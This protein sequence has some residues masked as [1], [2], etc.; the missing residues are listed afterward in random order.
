MVE[1]FPVEGCCGAHVDSFYRIFGT[2]YCSN[3]QRY[4]DSWRQD[5][6]KQTAK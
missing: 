2:T 3:S 4:L 1:V 6:N 5:Q